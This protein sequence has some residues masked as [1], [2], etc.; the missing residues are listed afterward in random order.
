MHIEKYNMQFIL[1]EGAT[2]MASPMKILI[3]EVVMPGGTS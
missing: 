3:Q 1:N 2:L